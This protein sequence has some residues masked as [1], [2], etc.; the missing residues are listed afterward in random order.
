MFSLLLVS[1]L[2]IDEEPED[3]TYN[4]NK[5]DSITITSEHELVLTVFNEISGIS[6]EVINCDEKGN[7]VSVEKYEQGKVPNFVFLEGK[8]KINLKAEKKATAK[9]SFLPIGKTCNKLMY[10]SN[11]HDLVFS[12]N[13]TT[14]SPETCFVF[15]SFGKKEI[16]VDK[17]INASILRICQ[18]DLSK[19]LCDIIQSNLTTTTHNFNSPVVFKLSAYN[20]TGSINFTIKGDESQKSSSPFETLY[21]Y[22]KKPLPTAL[23]TKTLGTVTEVVKEPLSLKTLLIVTA[24]FGI[25]IVCI[26]AV[27]KSRNH[28][29]DDVAELINDDIELGD[30]AELA[31]AYPDG[32]D[33]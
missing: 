20:E 19:G 22:V 33:A 12:T 8:S 4:M 16:K 32:E 14:F 27:C 30:N 10:I 15:A 17:Q 29:N 6:T 3:V 11:K 18:K 2:H 9:L 21:T 5:D 13:E 24:L 7:D 25:A 1:N 28:R 23:P 26:S 31:V